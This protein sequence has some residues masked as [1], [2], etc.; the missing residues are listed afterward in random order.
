[1]GK[2]KYHTPDGITDILPDE[3]AVKREIESRLRE[4]FTLN[5][6]QEIETPTLEFY[7]VYATGDGFAPQEGMFKFFDQQGRILSLRYD[8][9]IPAARIASTVLKDIKPP[10]RL[11]YIGNMFRYNET[12]G[13]K[14]KEFTQAGIELMGPKTAQSD[15]QVITTA[16]ESAICVGINDLQISLGDVEF[17]NGLI[18]EWNI[19]DEA[20]QL[21]PRLIDGKEMV[22]LEEMCVQLGLGENARKVLTNMTSSYGTYDLIDEMRLL[23]KNERSLK[24]LDNLHEV[25]NILEEEDVLKYVSLDLGMLQS[26]NYYT[27]I[28]FKG[29]TYGIGFPLLSG[30]RYDKVVGEFGR[31]LP[32]TG[33]SLGINFAMMALAR[34]KKLPVLSTKNLL[35]GY[36]LASRKKAFDYAKEQRNKKVRTEMDCNNLDKEKL[37]EYA[38]EKKYESVVYIDENGQMLHLK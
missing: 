19:G 13:G 1:M 22:A 28:I 29:F 30:G 21:L 27:G 16:I 14:Q 5:G 4:L 6:Y 12:G 3:C 9:T 11:S 38:I 17:F 32:S 26:L 33:F 24:A 31:N 18:E 8:G 37:L 36:D 7:D 2:W 25:L 10:I 35:V 34:Q 20:S 23:V 15:A